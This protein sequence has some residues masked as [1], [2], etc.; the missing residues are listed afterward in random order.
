MVSITF[1]QRFKIRGNVI[2]ILRDGRKNSTWYVIHSFYMTRVLILSPKHSQSC[3]SCREFLCALSVTSRGKLEQKLKWAF[4]MYDLDGN[5]YI[6]RQEML[7]IVTAIY[8][9]V[10]ELRTFKLKERI[11][12]HELNSL[13]LKISQY[14]EEI[15]NYF[16]VLG[17]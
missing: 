1:L 9:M 3:F 12:K 4:T 8:K 17:G 15:F 11:S 13:F 7:E 10:F 16:E 6:T 2:L 14:Q 5:G